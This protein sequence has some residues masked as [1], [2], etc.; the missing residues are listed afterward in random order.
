M[1]KQNI[2]IKSAKGQPG[3]N[4]FPNMPQIPQSLN[5]ATAAVAFELR[6]AREHLEL[7]LGRKV[8]FTNVT[9]ELGEPCDPWKELR[10]ESLSPEAEVTT[11]PAKA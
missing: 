8:G 9:V 4:E 11:E 7:M 2:T 3:V 1:S 10:E 6:S 5:A